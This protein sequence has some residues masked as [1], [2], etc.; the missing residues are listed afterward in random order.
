MMSMTGFGRSQAG[1][2]HV[3]IEV[4]IKSVNHRFL[5]TVFRLPRNYSALELDLRNIVAGFKF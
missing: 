5:D 2:K 3:A 1:S 4:E